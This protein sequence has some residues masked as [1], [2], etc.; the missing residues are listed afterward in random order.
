MDITVVIPTYNRAHTLARAL[1]SVLNQSYTAKEIIVVDDGSDDDTA[2]LIKQRYPN[3]VYIAQNHGGVSKARNTGIF[4]A[5]YSWIALLD[6]D[7]MWH[8]TK[9]AEQC[10]A[11]A[12]DTQSPVCHTDEIWIRNGNRVNPK[13]KH[14]KKGGRIFRHCLPLCAIS[15]SSAIISRELLIDIGLFDKSLPACEDYDLWLRIT[16]EHPVNFIDKPLITKYGGHADQLS[17]QHWGMDRFRVK[18]LEKVL[19]LESLSNDNRR[20]ALHMLIEKLDILAAGAQKHGNTALLD[21]M[22]KKQYAY[23]QQLKRLTNSYD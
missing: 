23:R 1:D 21:C 18:A 16:A 17:R 13:K 2:N 11:L 7:D 8:K 20:A 14:A 15:P 9:L 10:S 6:S 22:Q 4:A 19:R 5:S 3:I 12:K